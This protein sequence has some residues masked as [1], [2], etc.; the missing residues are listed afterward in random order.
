MTAGPAAATPA[1]TIP[2]APSAS[3]SKVLA[4]LVAAV[5]GYALMQTL[6]IPALGLLQ[7]RP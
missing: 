5:F 4:A 3:P 6:L 2:E 1:A 7:R